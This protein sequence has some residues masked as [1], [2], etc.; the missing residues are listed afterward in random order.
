ATPHCSVG[1]A[2]RGPPREKHHDPAKLRLLV[3][4]AI[5]CRGSRRAQH[6]VRCRFVQSTGVGPTGV[7]PSAT[8]GALATLLG[9]YIDYSGPTAWSST[10]LN[11]WFV[12]SYTRQDW[13]LAAN[14]DGRG[15]GATQRPTPSMITALIPGPQIHDSWAIERSRCRG[16]EACCRTGS[17]PASL[18]VADTLGMNRTMQ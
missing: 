17:P 2:K 7:G 15:R 10:S 11:Q 4:F 5:S 3:W 12:L 16:I 13:N 14:H 1:C 9:A 6:H 18:S 8:D